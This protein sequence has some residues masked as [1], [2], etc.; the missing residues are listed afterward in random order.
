MGATGKGFS[1][2]TNRMPA[3]I[4]TKNLWAT[5]GG[6]EGNHGKNLSGNTAAR[7]QKGELQDSEDLG[8]TPQ[9][10]YERDR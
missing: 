3:K 8:F 5:F 1:A 2:N 6:K 9:H 4:E 7:Y 10:P